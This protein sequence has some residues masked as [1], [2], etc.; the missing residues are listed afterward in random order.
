MKRFK[1]WMLN[2]MIG[3]LM[4]QQADV[5][6]TLSDMDDRL[7]KLFNELQRLEGLG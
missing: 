1:I 6:S 7:E 4:R 5:R 3:S 2:K